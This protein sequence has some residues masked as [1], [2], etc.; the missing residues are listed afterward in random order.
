MNQSHTLKSINPVN[1]M[2]KTREY[3]TSSLFNPT[4][5]IVIRRNRR[6]IPKLNK[7]DGKT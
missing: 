7:T 3:L 2:I 1:L 6:K 4:M 5:A